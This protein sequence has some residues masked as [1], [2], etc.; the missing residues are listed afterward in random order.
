MRRA[1]PVVAV[2]LLPLAFV[3]GGGGSGHAA[4]V[5]PP[6]PPALATDAA[7]TLA[8][9]RVDP[10]KREESRTFYRAIY[11]SSE[12]VASGFSGNVEAGQ[13]GTT[14]REFRDAIARRLN[15]FR[16]MAG[17]PADVTFDDE[18][19]RR[20]QLAQR[21]VLINKIA[22]LATY[23]AS[24]T[25]TNRSAAPNARVFWSRSSSAPTSVDSSEQGANDVVH[26]TPRMP[27]M[28]TAAPV[29]TH[30]RPETSRHAAAIPERAIDV[31][32]KPVTVIV[33][34]ASDSNVCVRAARI[35]S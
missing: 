22:M 31:P 6:S 16:A 26:R 19:N 33:T 8:K 18:L 7:P 29:S 10:R 1:F 2:A 5:S 4:Q 12:G 34:A 35:E 23:S 20:A 15:Y 25:T 21:A 17:V 27:R 13:A 28:P 32:L 3:V 30:T 11:A 24:P 9:L 14:S